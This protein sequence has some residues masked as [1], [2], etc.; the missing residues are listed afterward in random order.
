MVMLC[1]FNE[2]H[3]INV[4]AMLVLGADTKPIRTLINYT[5]DE[6]IAVKKQV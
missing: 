2:Q 3:F 5:D 1:K 4:E 6:L